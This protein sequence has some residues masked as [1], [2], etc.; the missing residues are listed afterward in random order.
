MGEGF[1]LAHSFRTQLILVGKAER[2]GRDQEVT[3][4]S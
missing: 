4:G 1:I 2:F 3:W